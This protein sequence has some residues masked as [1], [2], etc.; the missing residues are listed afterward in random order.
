MFYFIIA[1]F[2]LMFKI[3]STNFLNFFR[4]KNII[5]ILSTFIIKFIS[6]KIICRIAFLFFTGLL[7]RLIIIKYCNYDVFHHYD[8]IYANL[9]YLSIVILSMLTFENLYLMFD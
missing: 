9:Y 8:T 6:F 2:K 3:M 4:I 7:F 1:K 5:R